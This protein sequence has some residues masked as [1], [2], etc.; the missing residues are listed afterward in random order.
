[1]MGVYVQVGRYARAGRL[2]PGYVI[3]ENGCW[4]WIGAKGSGGYGSR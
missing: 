3:Q 4:E 2:A 1:M